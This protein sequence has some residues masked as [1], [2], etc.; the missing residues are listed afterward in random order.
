MT[1]EFL[2][3]PSGHQFSFYTSDHLIS[4]AFHSLLDNEL[5]VGK[6]YAALMIFDYYKQNRAKR[7]QQ[8]QAA[9]GTQVKGTYICRIIINSG[10]ILVDID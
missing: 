6:V 5:T 7:L 8:Q 3:P 10:N 9:P 1:S 2:V 4:R